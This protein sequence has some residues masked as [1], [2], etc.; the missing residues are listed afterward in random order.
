MSEKPDWDK[1]LEALL[2]VLVALLT[3][4]IGAALVSVAWNHI[5]YDL[6]YLSWLDAALIGFVLRWLVIRLKIGA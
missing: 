5:S 3:L 1:L 4:L 6:P 2:K